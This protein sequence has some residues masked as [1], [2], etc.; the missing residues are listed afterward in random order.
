MAESPG[1]SRDLS[2]EERDGER[3]GD[4]LNTPVVWYV[5]PRARTWKI[6]AV[7]LNTD[8]AEET[9]QRFRKANPGMK[10]RLG[11]RNAPPKERAR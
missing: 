6:A 11:A 8:N 3:L 9:L 1:T 7:I 4:K 2:L 10:F 5:P